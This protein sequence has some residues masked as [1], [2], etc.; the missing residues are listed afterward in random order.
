M[1]VLPS[2]RRV[3]LSTDRFMTY[4][5]SVDLANATQIYHSL[6]E[7]DDLLLIADVVYFS[8]NGQSPYFANFIAADW[9]TNTRSWNIMDHNAFRDW[10]FSTESREKRRKAI[11]ALKEE[12]GKIDFPLPKQVREPQI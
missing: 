12:M 2:G 9:E 8:A 5:A 4:F 10:L 11:A 6:Q 3:E 1:P 7:P